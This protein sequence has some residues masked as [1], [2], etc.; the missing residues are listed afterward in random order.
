[1]DNYDLIIVG[2]GSGN[3]IPEYLSDDRIAIV[4][5]GR[6][7]GTCLNVGCIPSKMFV[8]PG[9][10]ALWATHG[11]R[12]GV[13]AKVDHVDFGSIRDRTFARID[14]ISE[15]GR[16][17][18]AGGSPNVT[19]VEGTAHFTGPHELSVVAESGEVTELS[20]P[21]ILL[22]AGARPHQPAIEGLDT[23]RHHTSDTIMRLDRLPRRLGIIGSGFIAAEMAHVF[24]SYGSDVTI[25]SRSGRLLNSFDSEVADLITAS[26]KDRVRLIH[27]APTAVLEAGNEIHLMCP[28]STM[29][30]VDEL[31]VATGRVPNTDLLNPQAAGLAVTEDGR[32][33][34]DATMATSVAGIWA[35]G[36]ITNP[37]QLK[38]LANREAAVAFWNLAH[39]DSE[40]RSVDYHA[41]PAAVF[42]YPQVATVGLTEAEAVAAGH[43]VVVGR[44]DYGGTAYGWALVDET[45]FAKVIVEVDS[46]QIL[47]AQVVGPQ[48]SNL[49]QPVVQAMQFRQPAATVA[50]EVFYIHPAMTEVVENALL[51]ALDQIEHPD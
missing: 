47:G 14:A 20:A 35:A 17:Y 2:S 16:E 10:L 8:L 39:P 40:H 34:T 3:S 48:A 9:D 6:F 11:E 28:D 25:F 46:G 21:R 4:E 13:H 5:K 22:A 29:I 24:S 19:L 38:H 7:G 15:G 36:D 12:I 44:R 41:L 23:V 33:E 31:L 42:S 32:I 45:S 26:F 51:D 43:R 50:R 27:G 1:M 18:R 37:Y 49:I 30:E